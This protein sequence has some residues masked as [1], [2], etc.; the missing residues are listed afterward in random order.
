MTC[1]G[2]REEDRGIEEAR[3]LLGHDEQSTTRIYTG[4]RRVIRVMPNSRTA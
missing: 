3:K 1:R 2:N 4:R